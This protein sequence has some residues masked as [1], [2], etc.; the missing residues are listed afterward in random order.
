[1][2]D[3]NTPLQNRLANAAGSGLES[4]ILGSGSG[5]L[6]GGP[7]AVNQNRRDRELA[8]LYEMFGP[9]SEENDQFNLS[10]ADRDDLDAQFEAWKNGRGVDDGPR[11]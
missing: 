10:Q 7:G 8:K 3:L 11:Q 1:M 9:E 5:A 6:V 2:Y 4:L